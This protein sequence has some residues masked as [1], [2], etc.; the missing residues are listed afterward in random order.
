MKWQHKE[1][2][3]ILIDQGHI[4]AHVL[5]NH[6]EFR[7]KTHRKNWQS[8]RCV[9]PMQHGRVMDTRNECIEE[10]YEDFKKFLPDFYN[11]MPR[12]RKVTI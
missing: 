7:L 6:P 2:Y 10:L 12:K 9:G 11:R 3:S 5:E 4:I 8:W 1:G